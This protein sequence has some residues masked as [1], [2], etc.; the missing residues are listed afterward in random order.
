[1]RALLTVLLVLGALV[2]CGDAAPTATPTFRRY[3][4]EDV[5]KVLAPLSATDFRHVPRAT[6]DQSPNTATDQRDFTIPSIAPK[7]GQ[8]LLFDSAADVAGMQAWYAR[9][10]DLAP[11]VFV[12]G[13]ALIQLNSTLP[14][15]EAEQ[16][17]AALDALP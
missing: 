17:R 14:K 16:Y 11:Y 2:A 3:T 5:V 7:G 6:G 13:N 10:P 4:A 9:F 12:K 1:M 8:L 15:A